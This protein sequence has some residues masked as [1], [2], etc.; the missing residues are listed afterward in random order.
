MSRCIIKLLSAG[1][2]ILISVWKRCCYECFFCFKRTNARFFILNTEADSDKYVVSFGICYQLDL[3]CIR[4]HRVYGIDRHS[5]WFSYNAGCTCWNIISIQS[6]NSVVYLFLLYCSGL[7]VRLIVLL[8]NVGGK[9]SSDRSFMADLVY[10]I[11][12]NPP[13]VHFFLISG[14]RDFA[15]ML[16]RL[17][18]SN[19]NVLLACPNTASSVLCS[20]ATIMWPWDALV[21]GENFSPKHFNHPPDGLYGSWYGHYKGV[22]DVPF[23]ETEPKEPIEEPSASKHCAIPSDSMH[24]SVPKY[25]TTGIQETLKLFPEGISLSLLR[26]ELRKKNIDLGTDYFGH[27]KFSSFMHSMPDIAQFIKAPPNQ[28]EPYVTA[29]D[30]RLP[31]SGAQSSKT[32]SS[33]QCNVKEDNP[34]QTEHPSFTS[35]CISKLDSE[36]LS[37]FQSVDGK[38][39][40]VETVN[41]NPSTFAISSSGSQNSNGSRHFP[42]TVNGSP[43]SFAGSSSLSDALSEDQKEYPTV[44][45]HQK[46]KLSANHRELDERTTPET[47]SPSVVEKADNKDG[48]FKRIW[49]LWNGPE[50]TKYE[51][52]QNH[53]STSAEVVDELRIPLHEHNADHHRKLLKRLKKNGHS[54][55]SDCTAAASDNLSILS[56][57]ECCGNIKRDASVLENSEPCNGPASLPTSKTGEKDDTSRMNKGLFSWASRWW[58]FGKSDAGNCTTN[59]TDEAVTDSTEESESRSTST[60]GSGQV[61]DEIF[62]KSYFWDILEQQLSKPLGSELVSKVKTR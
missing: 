57:D 50:N 49:V 27:N 31:R 18:M 11:T 13:P 34:I 47:P 48:L 54:D 26:A 20:A 8:H 56:D 52:S 7:S 44:D 37:S 9:N 53:K 23:L 6:W 39:S 5:G 58:R 25:V 33:A 29:V 14:D 40:F 3:S 55:G 28:D 42:E 15:N 41:G 35:P 60:C 43:S 19:Y 45:A 16:H 12:Q 24:C 30:R 2:I 51:G 22:L 4:V 10:W 32:Q 21:K 17:R 59:V 61:P 36:P 1:I 46:S 38:R 62:T